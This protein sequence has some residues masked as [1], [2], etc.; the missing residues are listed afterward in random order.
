[1]PVS[2]FNFDAML[3]NSNFWKTAVIKELGISKIGFNP[4]FVLSLSEGFN[5]IS[6]FK[7]LNMAFTSSYIS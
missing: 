2:L 4:I 1:M 7:Y 6:L 3:Y 5:S